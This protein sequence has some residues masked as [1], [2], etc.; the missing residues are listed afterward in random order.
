MAK[1][2]D[3]LLKGCSWAYTNIPHLPRV[4]DGSTSWHV[5]KDELYVSSIIKTKVHLIGIKLVLNSGM[6]LLI[7]D[8]FVYLWCL[9][10]GTLFFKWILEI[11]IFFRCIVYT[12][13]W[14]KLF[15]PDH[16][17][18]CKII[19]KEVKKQSLILFLN[20]LYI[21]YKKQYWQKSKIVGN[22]EKI[23]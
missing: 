9:S 4:T 1:Q 13:F 23:F 18:E 16:L 14:I 6:G 21:I 2:D 5:Q 10:W 11:V 15:W 3:R 8:V 19:F 20:S 22:L 17:R 7:S 12:W